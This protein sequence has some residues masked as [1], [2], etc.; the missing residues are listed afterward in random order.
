MT[1]LPTARRRLR[2]AV[3]LAALL[4]ASAA[5]AATL[6]VTSSDDSI[7]ADDACTL[8][9]A[10]QN[11]NDNAD[12]NTDCA[13]NGSYGDDVI[14]FE[15]QATGLIPLTDPDGDGPLTSE[16]D[17]GVAGSSG[18]LTIDGGSVR[19]DAV[20]AS[21]QDS[22]FQVLADT[23]LRNMALVNSTGVNG[24]AIELSSGDLNV[25][26]VY[27]ANNKAIGPVPRPGALDTTP[28]G[29][30]GAIV[31]H[32]GN[33]TVTNSRF[34]NNAANRGGGAIADLTGAIGNSTD[35]STT[36]FLGNEADPALAAAESGESISDD[37]ADA[38]GNGG[39]IY[40]GTNG[41]ANIENAL[42][43]G[44]TAANEG[45]AVWSAGFD[46]VLAGVTAVGNT[47]AGARADGGSD[48]GGG[49][50]G[51][52]FQGVPG[53]SAEISDSRFA[54]N[55]ASGAD[56]SGGAIFHNRGVLRIADSL[57]SSNTAN[58][59]GGGIESANGRLEMTG[60]TVGGLRAAEGNMAGN[61]PG[62]GGGIHVGGNTTAVLDDSVIAF[63]T[64]TD[65]GGLWNGGS[66]SLELNNSTVSDN[67][68]SG[69]GG[70]LYQVS[71][72]DTNLDYVTVT[73]NRAGGDGGGL[74][75]GA[76]ITADFAADSS[77]IAGNSADGAGADVVEGG[78]TDDG[79]NVTGVD[80]VL[81]TL[82]L[83]GGP[84]A[85]HPVLAGSPALEAGNDNTCNGGDID[86]LDQ[87][88]AERFFDAT[89]DDGTDAACDS[90][91]FE[92]TD[93]V[94]LSVTNN[95]ADSAS[96]N[97]AGGDLDP[98]VLAAFGLTNNG[99]TQVTLSG[100]RSAAL[101]NGDVGRLLAGVGDD[102]ELVVLADGNGDGTLSATEA[103]TPPVAVLGPESTFTMPEF[104]FQS[105]GIV[106]AG[107]TNNYLV[108]LREAQAVVGFRQTAAPALA[109]AAALAL[110]G[111]LTLTGV[112]RRTRLLLIAAVLAV[113]A[114][115]CGGDGF[116]YDLSGGGTPTDPDGPGGPDPSGEGDLRLMVFELLLAE[117]VVIGDGL[118]V[119][120]PAIEVDP[121]SP[122]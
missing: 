79:N 94:V 75:V 4:G 83:Y 122:A 91:A 84:T 39:A 107:E 64:A 121:R 20:G 93:D 15:P 54:A 80:P 24:A 22:I 69:S 102:L 21:D 3:A 53:Y 111:A 99:D 117:D 48:D 52:Y 30:G 95:S 73:A 8:R 37:P 18:A 28:L 17:I 68:A 85:T 7:A 72:G 41:V 66:S 25:N 6:T 120:G 76:E 44:N 57:I 89:P 81:D 49:G 19:I 67:Q 27:F 103:D 23:T 50:G 14:Q 34:E 112:R 12:T 35:V 96:V 86:N 43:S 109:G 29:V 1:I 51:L 116:E 65:G 16:I 63:N 2:C 70:G 62:N 46:L 38:P 104:A 36:V 58:R 60:T 45:G 77:I 97:L 9:E 47:A 87:R 42:F 59:A 71:G 10:V 82:K 26:N 106:G 5:Q 56:G 100:L 118:P 31:N 74:A 119:Y 90:G 61:N 78:L 40:I 55:D 13:A 98:L 32:N 115:G 110:L 114:A 88:G 105:G 113:A 101:V 33:L 92:Q 11:A 108:V